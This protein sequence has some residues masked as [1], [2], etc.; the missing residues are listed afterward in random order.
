MPELE[1]TQLNPGPCRTYQIGVRGSKN[2]VIVDPLLD[3]VSRYQDTLERDGKTLTHVIDTH[4]HADHL[5]GA[6]LLAA[7]TGAAYAMHRTSTV[8]CLAERLDEGTTTVGDVPLRVLYT[9]GHTKDSITLVFPDRIMTGD[10]LFLDEG[11]AGRLDLPGGD[12]GEHWNSL[13]RILGLPANLLVNPAHD[14]RNSIP[15]DINTQKITN[16]YLAPR[17]K[18]DYL[19]FLGALRLG[20]ADWM[21]KVLEANVSCICDSSGVFIPHD[22]NVCEAISDAV[23]DGTA[24]DMPRINPDE[25]R[26]KILMGQSP[27]L[28]D[29]REAHELHGD[30]PPIAGSVNI[31]L[32]ML[33]HN[34][35]AELGANTREIVTICRSGRRARIAGHILRDA[36]FSNVR[37]L[38]GGIAAWNGKES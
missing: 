18:D 10:V 19:A 31:S 11:G 38:D 5:S 8:S 6:A 1:F 12:A 35:P 3:D 36:G 20:P 16:P 30:V 13:Q 9:P 21:T 37:I 34:A 7:R 25:L 29:V 14:Y 23:A 27:L 32:G 26:E 15:S 24:D 4:T 2:I 33:T 28:L 22:T 17:A